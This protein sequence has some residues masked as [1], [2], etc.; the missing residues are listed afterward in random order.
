MSTIRRAPFA[1][2]ETDLENLRAR[3]AATRWVEA[4]TVDDWSQ[5]PPLA[6]MRELMEYWAGSYDWRACEARI[7]A[8]NPCVTEIDGLDI[9]FLHARS[10]LADALPL[11]ITHGWPGSIAEFLDVIPMLTNPTAFGGRAEDAF[12]VIAPSLPGY[13]F[14]GKPAKAGWNAHRIANAWAELVAR[15][16]YGARWAAQGGDWGSVVTTII[17]ALAPA[18]LVGVHT[19]RPMYRPKPGDREVQG[20]EFDRMR[21][22]DNAYRS[23]D[24]GYMHIQK[25]RPQ[26]IGYALVDSPVAQAAW[27]Y[28]KLWKWTDHDGDPEQAICRD[29][30]LDNIALYWLTASG[31]SSARLYWE[32]AGTI[33]NSDLTVD[34]PSGASIF[35]AEISYTPRD[36]A[37]RVLTKLVYW[38]EAEKGGHFAA[39]EQPA[40]FA[41]EVRACFS[42]MR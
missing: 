3:I 29:R 38:N 32:A 7:N 42:L 9:H 28:E 2:A 10:P 14:S 5:G 39:W 36:W 40:I 4:E 16:G 24:A 27:I 26:T 20:A 13:G 35:P 11:V 12:H 17:G 34:V 8:L 33:A 31:G 6:A 1:I 19:N 25:S 21:S 37:S 23:A 15:L 22:L 30:M 18:G 41:R